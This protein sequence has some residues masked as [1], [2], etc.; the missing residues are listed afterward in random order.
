MLRGVSACEIKV[1]GPVQLWRGGTPMP[2]LPPQQRAVLAALVV[3]AGR[4]VPVDVLVDRVWA[5]EIPGVGAGLLQPVISKLRR[6]LEPEAAGSGQWRVLTTRAPGY[7]LQVDPEQVDA[8]RFADSV[9]SARELA[10]AGDDTAARACITRALSLWRGPAYADIAATFA[11]AEAARLGQLRLAALEF[12]AEL[13]LRLGRHVELLEDL[14][15]LVLAEPLR[16]GLRAGLMLALYRA[17]RAAEA[18]QVYGEGRALLVEELGID[19]SP[20][21]QRLHEQILR[22]D[23]ALDLPAPAPDAVPVPRRSQAGTARRPYAALPVPLTS[24]VG[25]DIELGEVAGELDAH[26]LVTLVGPG[27]SGKTRLALQVAR[28]WGDTSAI[29]VGL[30]ELAG[31]SDPG[32]V[33]QQVASAL[34]VLPGEDAIRALIG[35]LQDQRVLVVL[36]NCEHVIDSVAQLAGALLA[37][38]PGLLVLATSRE[39]LGVPGEVVLPIGPMPVAGPDSDAVRLFL[40]RARLAAPHAGGPTPQELTL[41]HRICARLDG[42]PLAVELAAA[43]L[44]T[45][46][47]AEVA[48]RVDDRFTLLSNGWRT[49][50]PHQRTLA[51]SVQWSVDLLTPLEREVF[52]AASVFS[53]GFAPDALDA[54]ALGPGVFDALRSLAAKSLV[55]LDRSR[56]RYRM[57]ETLR[58]FAASSLDEDSRRALADRHAAF[59]VQ[60][61]TNIEPT[62][63]RHG[64]ET[65]WARL[66]AE[67]HNVRAAL[68]HLLATGQGTAALRLA[69]GLSW[70]WYLRGG[71]QE[72]RRWLAAALTQAAQAPPTV[73]IRALLGDALLAYLAGD[74][75]SV[76]ERTEEIVGLPP[77]TDDGSLAQALVLRAFVRSLLW[78]DVAQAQLEVARGLELAEQSGVDWVRAEIAMT[79]GQFARV[80]GDHQGALTELDRACSIA[81]DI[82]HEWAWLSSQW[83]RAKVLIDLGEGREALDA[84]RNAVGT[85][86]SASDTTGT[87]AALLVAVGAAS[88]AGDPRAAA[89]LLGAVESNSVRVG[90]DPLRMD[91]VDGPA[92]LAAAKAAL[93]PEEF[94]VAVAEGHQLEL[95]D[96]R[97]FLEQLASPGLTSSVLA[98]A[99]P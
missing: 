91:P 1:L 99:S 37:N 44:T 55:E 76:W 41:I 47:L 30:V 87:L 72:G 45:L 51:A 89:V 57:L 58:Q 7:L 54:V 97:D 85:G 82:G 84:V 53:G 38:A 96:A 75:T 10:A 19:P 61:V 9:H 25:R 88:A 86:S 80:A 93:S 35:A 2:P 22:Q 65:G 14:P 62:L 79:Q 74:V 81:R 67:Q 50:L 64:S 48:A 70:W 39:P 92:Y 15:T 40:D 31:T 24:F 43:C 27:G 46:T 26:R 66:D 52:C 13:D 4:V 78:Q 6:V 8:T 18:L 23:P 16:E 36:D 34:A 3:D 11:E 83:V 94:Q 95:A 98:S 28:A 42:L 33:A 73:R 5:G 49:A 12:S 32:M 56:G 20:D 63:R 17:G 90:Y 60:L 21:L 29:P 77:G 69:G 59:F 71:V 68:T